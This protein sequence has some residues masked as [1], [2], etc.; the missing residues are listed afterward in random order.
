MVER[1][2]ISPEEALAIASGRVRIVA[3]PPPVRP[4]PV[5]AGGMPPPKSGSGRV[6]IVPAYELSELPNY[7]ELKEAAQELG[8]SVAEMIALEPKNDPFYMGVTANREAAEWFQSL[9]LRLGFRRDSTRI[10]L[11]RIHYRIISQKTPLL[12][13]DGEP[14]ENTRKDW[15]TLLKASLAARYLHLVPTEAFVDRRNAEAETVEPVEEQDANLTSFSDGLE[16]PEMVDCFD[17]VQPGLYLAKPVIR[18]AANVEL[19]IEKS[20]MD[21]ILRPLCQRYGVTFQTGLLGEVSDT[22]CRQAVQRARTDGRPTR[23]LYIS[24]FDA[25]GDSMP[26]AA[27]RKMEF[28][29]R[30]LLDNEGVELDFQL[31]PIALTHAQCLHYNLPRTPMKETESRAAR[32]EARYGE[33][34]TEL[35]ALEA[36]HPGE[37]GSIVEAEIGRYYDD[38]L[39]GRIDE[40]AS[41]ID[42]LCEGLNEEVRTRHAEE[43]E[44]LQ[45]RHQELDLARADLWARMEEELESDPARQGIENELDHYWPEPH[46]PDEDPDPLFDSKRSYLEQMRRY[47]QHQGKTRRRR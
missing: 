34:A 16:R 5:A 11:R 6:R 42:G 8:V 7:E 44:A 13:S 33:G 45:R 46:E 2:R 28:A 17:D 9:W 1:V 26:V 29:I 22:R 27:A 4:V 31:R 36:L 12:K 3:K 14:Y 38:T 40:H 19:W 37:F 43:I 41:E 15:N 35:D 25:G 47:K 21:D 24:D 39:Q 10:H 32:F 20:T 23:V 30:E 18:Q